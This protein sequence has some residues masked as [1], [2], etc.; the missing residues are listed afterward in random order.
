MKIHD[1]M[2]IDPAVVNAGTSVFEAMRLMLERRVSGLPVTD[3]HGVL[4]GIVSEGDFLRRGELG[5]EKHRRRWVEWLT[6]PGKLADEYTDAHAL[7]VG[8]IMTTD[9]Q[10]IAPDAALVEA[11]QAMEKHHI[12]RLPVTANGK[13]AGI[14]SRADLMR[15]FL[16]HVPRTTAAATSDTALR[17]RIAAE[18]DRQAW[19]PGA[20]VHVGVDGGVATL[21][22]V[23]VDDR[24]RRALRVL[25]ENVC[26][27][28]Q[29]RDRLTTIEP[30]TGAIVRSGD[31]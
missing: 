19:G 5:T 9:V 27:V 18:I 30:M 31:D 16:T 15:A 24:M 6:S 1:V 2:T 11:V 22:G 8:Q 29:V 4:V 26:G 17:D 23:L 21:H 28:G 25:A 7:S 12:K 3:A 10:T 20:L 13:L 14:V